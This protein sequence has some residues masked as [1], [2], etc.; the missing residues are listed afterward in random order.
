MNSDELTSVT[1]DEVGDVLLASLFQ[2]AH[3]LLTR[4]VGSV[5]EQCEEMS[6]S[7]VRVALIVLYQFLT[8]VGC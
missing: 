3:E 2:C 4:E 6:D 7:S 5:D 8:V 1:T